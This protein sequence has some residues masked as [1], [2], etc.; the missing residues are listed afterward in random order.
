MKLKNTEQV[1]NNYI[2]GLMM[3][4]IRISRGGTDWIIL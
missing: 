3:I 2:E 4:K 1:H